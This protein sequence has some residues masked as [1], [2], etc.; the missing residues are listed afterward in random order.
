MLSALIKLLAIPPHLSECKLTIRNIYAPVR[1]LSDVGP[2]DI[3]KV[4]LVFSTFYLHSLTGLYISHII[5]VQMDNIA[6]KNT[7]D[8]EKL[9]TASLSPYKH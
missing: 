2:S 6:P 5:Q 8:E 1:L 9:L 3:A 4:A 7:K